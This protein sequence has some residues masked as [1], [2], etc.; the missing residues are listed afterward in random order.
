MLNDWTAAVEESDIVSLKKITDA[1]GKPVTKAVDKNE[2]WKE[3]NT[4]IQ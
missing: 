4:T 2:K 1:K 3:T